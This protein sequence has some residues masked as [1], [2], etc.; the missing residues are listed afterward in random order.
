MNGQ[1]GETLM[2]GNSLDK[3]IL[4]ALRAGLQAILV[5]RRGEQI[6]LNVPAVKNLDEV[7]FAATLRL[8]E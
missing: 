2:I 3:D 6:G 8:G 7:H 5:N 4:G 1:A